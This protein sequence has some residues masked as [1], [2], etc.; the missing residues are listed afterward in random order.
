MTRT[1]LPF[2]AAV[3]AAFVLLA[4]TLGS[5]DDAPDVSDR[6]ALETA[7]TDGVPREADPA[8]AE[9]ASD[10]PSAAPPREP[11]S[12]RPDVDETWD[13]EAR[14]VMLLRV[15][16]DLGNPIADAR[17]SAWA[18]RSVHQPGT[19]M[20]WRGEPEVGRTDGAGRCE[21]P[22]WT[23]AVPESK[24]AKITLSVSHPHFATLD[25]LDLE[26]GEGEHE[27]VLER[28]T[29]LSVSGWIDDPAERIFEVDVHAYCPGGWL[30]DEGW[31]R[32]AGRP[33]STLQAPPGPVTLWIDAERHG[34]RLAS[35]PHTALLAKGAPEHI[36]LQLRPM[37]GLRGRI[38]RSVPRPIRDGL[39][40]VHVTHSSGA[41]DLTAT[42]RQVEIAADGTFDFGVLPPG[43]AEVI[44]LC[45]G[46]RSPW[47]HPEGEPM[48]DAGMERE[49]LPPWVARSFNVWADLRSVEGNA[50]IEVP[51]LETATCVV[52]VEDQDGAPLADASVT[53]FP[54]AR[55][56]TGAQLFFGHERYAGQTG[57]DGRAT[58][59]GLPGGALYFGVSLD[60]YEPRLPRQA[61]GGSTDL[62]ADLV[63]GEATEVVVQMT[64]K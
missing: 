24:T 2:L 12:N 36:H 64:E 52:R 33:P 32:A 9:R 16:D 4:W 43:L 60:R 61:T 34:K 63:P 54:N 41:F 13:P 58:V 22:Y 11:V 46:Y 57:A 50:E 26:V 59:A 3:I 15:V 17:I 5:P 55:F 29:L 30:Q 45:D 40:I 56:A 31:Q 62:L 25:G 14:G 7:R 18:M 6:H 37:P 35:A 44:A 47:E 10:P 19:H 8:V 49:D 28:G 53:F 21:L 38:D 27:I 51:M 48:T 20:L 42:Q 1:A 39:A 23:W